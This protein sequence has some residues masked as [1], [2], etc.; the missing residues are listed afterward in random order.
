MPIKIALRILS[1]RPVKNSMTAKAVIAAALL[2]SRHAYETHDGQ[3][4]GAQPD[5]HYGERRRA[6][7]RGIRFG[8]AAIAYTRCRKLET[9]A[10]TP[11]FDVSA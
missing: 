10:L 6:I 11:N 5:R 2:P 3:R 1:D 4:R 9:P 7:A 8:H